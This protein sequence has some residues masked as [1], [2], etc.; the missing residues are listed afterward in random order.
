MIILISLVTLPPSVSL[1]ESCDIDAR[2]DQL[3]TPLHAAAI[4]GYVRIIERLV[5][6]GAD[7]NIADSDGDTALHLT[8]GRD[9][10]AS[11]SQDT[12]EIVK[13]Q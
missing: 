9:N 6:Y 13:V 5:G 1:Q 7:L 12:P 10:M 11:P 3:Y 4:K 2:T 8:L